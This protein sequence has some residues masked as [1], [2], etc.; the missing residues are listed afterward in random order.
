[1]DV[2]TRAQ[3]D[4]T[5]LS[6]L[7]SLSMKERAGGAYKAEQLTDTISRLEQDLET[8][9]RMTCWMV[10]K[11]YECETAAGRLY[12]RWTNAAVKQLDT[13]WEVMWTRCAPDAANW[14][15][16]GVEV[17]SGWGRELHRPRIHPRL[18]RLAR[19]LASD[20]TRRRTVGYDLGKAPVFIGFFQY[21]T[22]W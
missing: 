4:T 1:M 2:D 18:C 15:A 16:T 17:R 6:K 10:V 14:L 12:L 19:R 3:E 5:S 8:L 7:K 13:C 9:S 21:D 11:V 20:H 22:R